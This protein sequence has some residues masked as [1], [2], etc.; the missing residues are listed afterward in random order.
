MKHREAMIQP[1]VVRFAIELLALVAACEVLVMFALPRLAPGV[2]GWH[3]ALL[4]AFLLT[5]CLVPLVSWRAKK[6]FSTGTLDS[7]Q[8]LM[9][10]PSSA[11]LSG[12]AGVAVFLI[13]LALSWSG[14][15]ALHKNENEAAI[16]RFDRVAG[17]LQRAI[18]DRFDSV[19]DV[20]ESLAST[21]TML[22][23]DL[24]PDEFRAWMA[25]RF[26]ANEIPGVRGVGFIHRVERSHLDTW[27]AGQRALG[28]PEFQI[29][30]RGDASDLFVI[31][32]IEPLA[33]NRPAWGYDIGSEAT[34]RAGIEEAIRTGKLTMTRR[35]VLVQD[36]KKRPGFLLMRPLYKAG[37]KLDTDQARRDNLVGVIYSPI[38]M[39]EFL[40][41]LEAKT[42]MALKFG[43]YDSPR[44]D[45]KSLLAGALIQ[46]DVADPRKDWVRYYFM[47]VGRQPL[48]LAMEGG[49]HTDTAFSR[50]GPLWV[51][52]L[53]SI[54]SVALALSVWLLQSGRGR[55]EALAQA[56]TQDLTE[57]KQSAERALREQA[58]I[59]STLDRFSIMCIAE[60]DGRIAEVNDLFCQLSGYER[61]ELLGQNP[62]MLSSG[63]HDAI[64]WI[65]VWQ[66]VLHGAPWVGAVCNRNKS[67]QLY[68]IQTVIAPVHAADGSIDKFISFGYDI[69][70]SR[71]LQEEMASNAE[72]FNLAID[73]GHDG[74]WD[75]MNVH[76]HEEWWSPQ[77]YRLL[78]YEP[79]EISADLV[80]FDQMLHPDHQQQ[81]FAAIEAAF[82]DRRPFDVEYR[83]KT[84]SGAY[85]W[86]RSRAKVYFDEFGQATRMAGSIQDIH[87][88][89]ITQAQLQEKME[90]ISAIFSLSPDGFVS[91]D[92]HGCVSYV[93][94]AFHMLTGAVQPNLIGM[95]EERFNHILFACAVEGQVVGSVADVRSHAGRVVLEMR[96]PAKRMLELRLS[97]G[98]GDAVSQVL[99]LRDVTHETEVDQM[100]SAFLSMAAHELR[101]PMASIYGFTELLLTRELKPEKQKDLL[102]RIYRQ[103]EAMA[104]IINELLDLARIEARRGTD[105]SFQACDLGA[106]VEK[107]IGDFKPPE[108]RNPPAVTWSDE[109]MSA[110]VDGKK[111]QQAVLNILSNAY[112]Y[113]P[114]GGSVEV[115]FLERQQSGRSQC[116]I[117]ISDHGI[118]LSPEQLARV[119]E[120]FYRADKS[121]NIP[122]TGLGVTIVKE[123]LELMGGSMDIDS[124]LGV[125]TT[126]T[127][128]V[129]Q[130]DYNKLEAQDVNT[131]M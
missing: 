104:G 79:D 7:L 21:M 116:A 72:R 84:K 26:P 77:F 41:G 106:L 51:G 63:K 96:P 9:A 78:G 75:W 57:A 22:G 50:S 107:V 73:G 58:T 68:W 90:Q 123:I 20:F 33:N 95:D 76:S 43:V 62:R 100:K 10:T 52:G 83:L 28:I 125:G 30:T 61:N 44:T 39:E 12:S 47:D 105:F 119:G 89:K 23:R 6:L 108:G 37:A 102:G 14:A 5:V 8:V 97:S 128:W 59:L 101:T 45:A 92:E 1:A 40:Q 60:P 16:A 82:Q 3:Q 81:T 15:W 31:S 29:K 93:S 109:R 74:L 85:R 112:K 98:Q 71:N 122:G 25:T 124:D 2:G 120:R 80:T 87:D 42:S 117:R 86:F 13:G 94:P 69:T 121:G 19:E 110:W 32:R 34:R 126:V 17:Q 27:L 118:G 88:R 115:S 36:G 129:S 53:G 64:F 18:D 38:V 99:A 65:E 4:D 46:S 49:N 127:L 114:Q 55:A 56:M 113:S 24:R 103:S 91:F 70:A 130:V 54:L 67:G 11:K 111:M 35:I 131:V 48:T 66:S